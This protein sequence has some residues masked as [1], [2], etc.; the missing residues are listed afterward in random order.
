MEFPE[1]LCLRPAAVSPDADA[2]AR[3]HATAGELRTHGRDSLGVANHAP[4]YLRPPRRAAHVPDIHRG[5]RRPP[6]ANE[7]PLTSIAPAG[8]DRGR[9]HPARRPSV[10]AAG[11]SFRS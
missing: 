9:A 7:Y 8:A 1:A 10:G 5:S 2:I 3:A 11:E 4:R 6:R